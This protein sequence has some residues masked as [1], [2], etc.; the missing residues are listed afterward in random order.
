MTVKDHEDMIKLIKLSK[1]KIILSGRENPLYETE[2]KS[3]NRL[4]RVI[5]NQM[6]GKKKKRQSEIIWFN[7]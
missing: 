2:L 7:F 5:V 1:G 4:E 6:S 3:W